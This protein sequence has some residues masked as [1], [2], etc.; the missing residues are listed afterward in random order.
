[1]G[2]AV[3]NVEIGHACGSDADARQCSYEA[4]VY[5]L[6]M[7]K[8]RP[9]AATDLPADSEPAAGT[10]LLPDLSRYWHYNAR[11]RTDAIPGEVFRFARCI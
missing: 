6:T 11:A 7:D 10:L 2:F 4:A 1:M 3:P 9:D 5:S 8:G